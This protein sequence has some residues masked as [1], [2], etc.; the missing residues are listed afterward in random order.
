M[1]DW[2]KIDQ[3]I[4]KL[5]RTTNC[6][7]QADLSAW[8]CVCV[9]LSQRTTTTMRKL[10]W[11]KFRQIFVVVYF[12]VRNFSHNNYFCSLFM[13]HLLLIHHHHHHHAPSH[14]PP[15][16]VGRQESLFSFRSDDDDDGNLERRGERKLLILLMPFLGLSRVLVS[17]DVNMMMGRA[18]DTSNL[19][20]L[21]F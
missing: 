16:I 6:D 9:Y 20:K 21:T 10:V 12:R 4:S 7:W 11:L 5:V 3:L 14:P 17:D 19:F 2:L 8:N 13:H 1:R 15:L 18:S